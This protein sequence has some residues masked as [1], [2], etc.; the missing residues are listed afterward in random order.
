MWQAEGKKKIQYL[1]FDPSLTTC[2][3]GAGGM[4]RHQYQMVGR[5][6]ITGWRGPGMSNVTQPDQSNTHIAAGSPQGSVD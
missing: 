4:D 3:S 5:T 2:K 6:P 1:S